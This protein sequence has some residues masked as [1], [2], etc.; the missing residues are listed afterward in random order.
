[1]ADNIRVIV[2]V[3]PLLKFEDEPAWMTKDNS[4]MSLQGSN[5]SNRNH[6]DTI[7]ANKSEKDVDYSFNFESIVTESITS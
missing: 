4:I 1:M 7:S 2:R 5:K 6:K 3:R